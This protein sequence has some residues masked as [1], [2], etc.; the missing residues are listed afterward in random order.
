MATKWTLLGQ[1]NGSG[2]STGDGIVNVNPTGNGTFNVTI[3]NYHNLD[4]TNDH[5]TADGG[6]IR[7]GEGDG[8]SGNLGRTSTGA[9]SLTVGGT[10]VFDSRQLSYTTF[11]DTT[12][13]TGPFTNITNGGLPVN[14][15]CIAL[16]TNNSGGAITIATGAPNFAGVIIDRSADVEI[17]NPG[18]CL[19]TLVRMQNALVATISGLS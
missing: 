14:G 17:P 7:V 16:L 5:A 18:F 9:V 11:N 8:T 4:L 6:T 19:I 13:L 2:D 12:N 1:K 3:D 10:L 15:Q